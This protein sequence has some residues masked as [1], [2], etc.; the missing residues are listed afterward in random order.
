MQRNAKVPPGQNI[1]LCF[2]KERKKTTWILTALK[3]NDCFDLKSKSGLRHIPTRGKQIS[4][5]EKDEPRRLA[6]ICDKQ[7]TRLNIEGAATEV[8]QQKAA[9]LMS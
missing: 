9:R 7:L 6:Q 1:L 8:Q 4:S 5:A 2:Q 3:Q